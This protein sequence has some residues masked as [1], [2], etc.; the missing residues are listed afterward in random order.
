M[1]YRRFHFTTPTQDL[2][3]FEICLF[4]IQEMFFNKK[5]NQ[6]NIIKMQNPQLNNSAV[7]RI[8]NAKLS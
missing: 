6:Y 3:V 7:L 5:Q 1:L 2:F 4:E 8:K